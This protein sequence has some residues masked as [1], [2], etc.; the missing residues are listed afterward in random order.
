MESRNY[1][2]ESAEDFLSPAGLDTVLQPELQSTRINR[3]RF[4]A[5]DG[6]RLRRNLAYGWPLKATS[7][8]IHGAEGLTGAV[9]L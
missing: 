5:F 2:E 9:A 7:C 4:L 8:M 6:I 3:L 1:P